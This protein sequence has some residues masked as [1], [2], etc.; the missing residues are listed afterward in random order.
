MKLYLDE[1]GLTRIQAR[2]LCAVACLTAELCRPPSQRELLA[3]LGLAPTSLNNI[4]EMV[5]RLARK[6]YLAYEP[7]LTRTMRLTRPLRWREVE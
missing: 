6:G 7:K 3:E 4:C 5:N 2:F 1:P